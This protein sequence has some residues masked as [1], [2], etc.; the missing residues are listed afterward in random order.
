MVG[1][2]WRQV[3]Q[4]AVSAEAYYY[5]AVCVPIVVLGAPLGSVIGSHFHRQILAGLIYVLDTVA[6]ISAYA[7]VPLTKALIGASVGIMAF[8]F[9]F[10]GMITYAGQKIMEGIE[11]KKEQ[12]SKACAETEEKKAGDEPASNGDLNHKPEREGPGHDIDLGKLNAGYS[13]SMNQL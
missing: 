11:R 4:Q 1:F 13:L 2:Y 3:I 5:L 7:I 12:F 8:G 10:F 6:L 9:V